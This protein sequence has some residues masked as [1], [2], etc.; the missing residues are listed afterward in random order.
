VFSN[1]VAPGKKTF[2]E[3][4]V[5]HTDA[6]RSGC[7]SQPDFASQQKW[8]SY[9]GKVAGSDLIECRVRVILTLM[10]K[11]LHIHWIARFGAAEQAILRISDRPH[12]GYSPQASGDFVVQRRPLR[13]L[14]ARRYSIYSNQQ[15][16]FSRIAKCNGLQIP[17][18]AQEKPGAHYQQQRKSDLRCDQPFRKGHALAGAG[19]LTA[20]FSQ[21]FANVHT[22]CL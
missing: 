1:R 7:V 18:C 11:A 8:N 16:L 2:G 13:I 5:D 6:R 21:T 14:I 12:A 3:C 22:R 10:N 9:A 17:K 15:Q 4:F 19:C 20:C